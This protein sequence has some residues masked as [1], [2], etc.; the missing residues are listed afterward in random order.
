MLSETAREV[1]N[2]FP[3]GLEVVEASAGA[4]PRIRMLQKEAGESL[5]LKT[6]TCI[7]RNGMPALNLW[8]FSEEER[9][10]IFEYV[11]NLQIPRARAAILET[12]V[13]GTEFIKMSL[14]LLRGLF[15]AGVLDFV[16]AKKRWRVNYGLDLERSMLAVPYHAKEQPSPRSEFSHPDTAIAL[17]CLSYYYTGLTD[18]QIHASFEELLLS[19]HAQESYVQW[20]QHC[21]DVPKT[22]KHLNGVNLRDKQQCSQELFPCL[23]FSKGLI[24]YYLN[25]LVFPK[26]MKEFSNKLSSSG[27][28]S[29]LRPLTKITADLMFLGNRS[30]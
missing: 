26:Q 30:R 12:K 1:L 24:D 10:V 9:K 27:W 18:E 7:C 13:F 22:L 15:A 25:H 29:L 28:V 14:L 3:H 6:A 16:F 2:E 8:T 5:L 11:T 17:T 19:D 4:F 23:R 21:E 20:I